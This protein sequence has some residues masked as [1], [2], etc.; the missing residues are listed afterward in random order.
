MAHDIPTFSQEFEQRSQEITTLSENLKNKT[1]TLAEYTQQRIN[2]FTKF[3]TLRNEIISFESTQY[4]SLN[5]NDKQLFT[6][7]VQQMTDLG[8]LLSTSLPKP[9]TLKKATYAIK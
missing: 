7:I 2:L 5:D 1:I 4:A 9:E 3:N 6:Q 8:N